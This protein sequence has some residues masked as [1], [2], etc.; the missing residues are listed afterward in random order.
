MTSFY[1]LAV[2]ILI[3]GKSAEHLVFPIQAFESQKAC[4]MHQQKYLQIEPLSFNGD[5]ISFGAAC[6]KHPN[7]AG[8]PVTKLV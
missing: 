2:G 7:P 1:I 8:L 6:V 4:E 5:K 3:N